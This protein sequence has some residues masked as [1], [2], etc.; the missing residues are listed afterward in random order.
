MPWPIAVDC[1][2]VAS[3]DRHGQRASPGRLL[4]R[5]G[6]LPEWARCAVAFLGVEIEADARAH[7]HRE[8][9]EIDDVLE[10]AAGAVGPGGERLAVGPGGAVLIP[11]GC[12]T[13]RRMTILDVVVPP[14]DPDDERID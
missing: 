6:R 9:T 12:G 14:F 4:A 10:C 5:L 7:D 1:P 3:P 8:H 13:G 11:L 2:I